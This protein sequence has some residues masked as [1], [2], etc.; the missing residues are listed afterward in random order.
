MVPLV[1]GRAGFVGLHHA[2]AKGCFIQ[3]IFEGP[4]SPLHEGFVQTVAELSQNSS[5]GR[6]VPPQGSTAPSYITLVTN[7]AIFGRKNAFITWKT[8][9]PQEER[10]WQVRYVIILA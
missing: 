2:L 6:A 9:R 10:I 4:S 5:A 1:W 8:L 3:T 7:T